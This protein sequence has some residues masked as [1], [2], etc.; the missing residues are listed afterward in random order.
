MI[1]GLNPEAIRKGAAEV[2]IPIID[3]E[4]PEFVEPA[5]G[6]AISFGLVTENQVKTT[7]LMSYADR[8]QSFGLWFRQL[9][10]ESL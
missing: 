1:A 4:P 3:D 5:I 7:V 9:W 10:A 6:A 8:L 2:L